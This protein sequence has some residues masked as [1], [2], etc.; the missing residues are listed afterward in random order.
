ML[1]MA[2]EEMGVL[3]IYTIVRLLSA[4]LGGQKSEG[5]S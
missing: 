2:D 1:V 5:D 4:D 3:G